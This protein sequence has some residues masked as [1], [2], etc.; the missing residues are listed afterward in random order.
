VSIPKLS[1]ATTIVIV[2]GLIFDFLNG[3]HDS[4]NIVATVIS[5]RAMAPRRV[6]FLSA[7]AH[8]FAPFMF[9]I[10]VATVIGHEVVSESAMTLPVIQA[11]LI[12][13]I[14]WDILTWLWGTPSSSSHAL[15][16][17]LIGAVALDSGWRALQPSGVIK[18][19]GALLLSPLLGLVAGYVIMR[20][21]MFLARGASPRI[22]WLFKRGQVLTV[23]GLSLSHGTNDA[24]KTMGIITMALLAD[25]AIQSFGVPIW[26]IAVCAAAMALGTSF[27]GWRL[28]RTLGLKFY[29]I[30]PLHAFTVQMASAVVIMGAALL[31]GPVSIT[32]VVSATIMG[33]GS[34]E[35]VRKVHWGV[36]EQII[37]AWLLTIPAT[38]AMA[39]LVRLAMNSLFQ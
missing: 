35:H 33:V 26:V 11:A 36:A 8:L 2:L 32:Q 37:R 39:A 38:A 14:A 17:G 3:F 13:A 15:I 21:V 18:V 31:G 19:M 28:I 9:G 5:S 23:L 16:G 7:I 12:A 24:Q 4:S 20:T 25:G 34:A 27:G 30:R 29:K 10:A 22:N 6:L 1:S